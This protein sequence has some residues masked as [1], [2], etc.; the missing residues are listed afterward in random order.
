MYERRE[1]PGLD[2]Y[3]VDNEGV[4]WTQRNRAGKPVDKNS[5]PK[6]MKSKL[7][8]DG[9]PSINLTIDTPKQ[10]TIKIQRLV[11]MAFVGKCP[12]GMESC[13]NNGIRTDN[14]P[15]NLRWDTR[16]ANQ[17]D[18]VKHGTNP[19]SNQNGSNHIHAK[20][21][22]LQVRII[23]KLKGKMPHHKIAWYFGV[24]RQSVGLI[25]GNK[26]WTHI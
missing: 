17:L 2:G 7:T 8:W 12:D 10:K 3:L 4:V 5:I 16:S 13:H 22:E 14:R 11:L 25:L 26:T 20:L 19:F 6:T 21:N 9:Y 18:A 23:R 24:C 15:C 1:I